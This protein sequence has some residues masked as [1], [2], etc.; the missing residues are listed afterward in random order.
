ML[1]DSRKRSPWFVYSITSIYLP[2]RE[3]YSCIQHRGSPEP[4]LDISLTVSRL[5]FL[6][7]LSVGTED[8]QHILCNEKCAISERV[9]DV[10]G[11][12]LKSTE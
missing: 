7:N 12:M 3:L 10:L 8:R 2:R 1:R 4:T 9:A 5:L 6:S 11:I